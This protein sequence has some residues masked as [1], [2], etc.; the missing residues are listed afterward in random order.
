MPH[1]IPGVE[2]YE[3]TYVGGRHVCARS[4]DKRAMRCWGANDWGQLGNGASD[5]AGQPT[6]TE[7]GGLDGTID[8]VTL[9]VRH[10]CAYLVEPEI[11]LRCWGANDYGQIGISEPQSTVPVPATEVG[12]F[13]QHS[14]K[15]SEHSCI[16]REDKTA[17]CY[18]LNDAGQLG[19]GKS[20][21]S[22][23]TPVQVL[24]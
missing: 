19:N 17:W 22:E 4:E 24:F 14:S 11:S 20:G 21:G 2:T 23:R 16:V 9:G 10:T 3:R 6:P 18:G 15:A 5:E 8:V 1:V 7:V 12:A 13:V